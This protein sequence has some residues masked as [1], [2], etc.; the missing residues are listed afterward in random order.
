MGERNT[1]FELG[2]APVLVLVLVLAGA[3]AGCAGP[4]LARD[5]TLVFPED[6]ARGAAV[7]T[8]NGVEFH[9]RAFIPPRIV[10]RD[11]REPWRAPIGFILPKSGRFTA[12]SSATVIATPGLAVVLRPSDTRVP[13]WGGEILVRLEVFAPAP[14]DTARP[15][16]RFVLVVDRGARITPSRERDERD[17][18]DERDELEQREQQQALV[19]AAL[20]ALGARDRVGVVDGSGQPLLVPVPGR[21]RTL[22]AAAVRKRAS[23]PRVA[24][25]PMVALAAA[26]AL[27]NAPTADPSS[28]PNARIVVLSDA[29]DDAWA[30]PAIA[31]EVA[32]LAGEGVRISFIGMSSALHS[33]RLG[34]LAMAGAGV[35][36]TGS[37]LEQRRDAVH[38]AVPPSGPVRFKDVV[39]WFTG[40]PAP[41]HVLEASSGEVRWH[42]DAGE[43]DLGDVSAGE[44]RAEML[45]V[46]VPAWVP[47]EPFALHAE[48]R[49][50]DVERNEERR[51][52]ADLT[53][54]YDDDIERI[55]DS[56]SGD[57]IAF[58]SALATLKRLEGAFVGE[59]VDRFGGLRALATLHARSMSLLAR[60]TSDLAIREQADVLSAL[61]SPVP[62]GLGAGKKPPPPPPASGNA[63]G[64]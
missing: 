30:A 51:V 31:Q 1:R 47:G 57:V 43:I 24:S 59:G 54:V 53:S 21:Y 5:G 40:A 38:L 45:R 44:A 29:A 20:D 37:S 41:S 46:S 48:A 42:L 64:R 23:E 61:L 22:A 14:P 32:R 58:A 63:K 10:R 49:F 6:G 3:A 34:D 50:F 28:N 18:H 55:A 15:P 13:S 36:G 17:E 60:D 56:R 39:V 2:L 12:T 52:A 62:A 11:A 16:E 33:G 25:Q 35:A 19:D 4:Y 7:L 27:L 8:A 9:D 26:R